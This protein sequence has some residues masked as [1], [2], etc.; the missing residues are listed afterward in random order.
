MSIIRAEVSGYRHIGYYDSEFVIKGILHIDTRQ[1]NFLHYDGAF[2]FSRL[3]IKAGKVKASYDEAEGFQMQQGKEAP[4]GGLLNVN[5]KDAIKQIQEAATSYLTTDLNAWAEYF[6]LAT[7]SAGPFA[8]TLTQCIAFPT[9]KYRC[10]ITPASPYCELIYNFGFDEE[11]PK[12]ESP[13]F[14]GEELFDTKIDL[15]FIEGP[16]RWLYSILLLDDEEHELPLNKDYSR[17]VSLEM[18]LDCKLTF[19]GFQDDE[20]TGQRKNLI[21]FSDVMR[22]K[23]QREFDSAYQREKENLESRKP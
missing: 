23:K 19:E 10:T 2:G 16:A 4:E 13:L 5:R 9:E 11:C 15:D 21:L 6:N 22:E 18:A 20:Q 17:I 7:R 8:Y 14:P 1:Y 3:E 12:V